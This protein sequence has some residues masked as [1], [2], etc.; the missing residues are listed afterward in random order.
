MHLP[1]GHS[2]PSGKAREYYL[3]QS[4]LLREPASNCRNMQIAHIPAVEFQKQGNTIKNGNGI[5][6]LRIDYGPGY[7]IYFG[8]KGM[9]TIILLIGGDKKTQDRDIA[10]AKQYWLQCEEL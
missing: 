1:D 3:L 8:K 9:L 2:K 7:R 5:C 6:E 10:K 4:E